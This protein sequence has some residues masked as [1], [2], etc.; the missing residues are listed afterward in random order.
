VWF[1]L[2]QAAL[3]TLLILPPGVALAWVLARPGW[4]GRSLVETLVSLP[5]V[6]PPTAVGLGLLWLLGRHGPLGGWAYRAFGL[7]LAFTWRAVVVASAVMAFPLLVRAARSAFEEIDPRLPAVARTLGRRRWQVFY[8][9][10]LPLAWRGLLS[11]LILAF[12]RALGE[13]GATILVAGNI[14]GR[15]QTLS[16]A[17]FQQVQM[18][19]DGE[20]AKLAGIAVVL[21][22]LAL[23]GAE[24]LTRRR[25]RTLDQ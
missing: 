2:G 13:F 6:L 22:A 20:A 7:E 5:L 11:G 14:P 3:A 12:A 24:A 25:E 4:R 1:T 9:I 18:G 8:E 19:R 10:E 16:L 15:T 21:A 23:W 17:L